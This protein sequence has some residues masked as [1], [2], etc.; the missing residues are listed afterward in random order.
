MPYLPAEICDLIIEHLAP[1]DYRARKAALHAL[2]LTNSFWYHLAM[3]E[4]WTYPRDLD[5]AE[6]ERLF[7]RSVRERP[8]LGMLVRS[9]K[10]TWAY[11]QTR[12][13]LVEI[14]A[15][16]PNLRGLVIRKEEEYSLSYRPRR[17]T[18]AH[19][20]TLAM[21]LANL[22][23]L[24]SL[25]LF[26][27]SG[28]TSAPQPCT[29]KC[30][31]WDQRFAMA[32]GKLQSLRIAGWEEWLCI[33]LVPH[34]SDQIRELNFG[35]RGV[36][37]SPFNCLSNGWS[38]YETRGF[39]TLTGFC[40]VVGTS[41]RVLRLRGHDYNRELAEA[42]PYLVALEELDTGSTELQ[43]PV[44]RILA[45]GTAPGQSFRVLLIDN[46][47]SL[48]TSSDISGY[49]DTEDY[50][51]VLWDIMAAIIRR[52]APTLRI[53]ETKAA[54]S[55]SFVAACAEAPNLQELRVCVQIDVGNEELDVLLDACPHVA[56]PRCSAGWGSNRAA[57]WEKR[58]L[59]AMNL[60]KRERDAE[61][62]L[63]GARSSRPAFRSHPHVN[64]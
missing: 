42:L 26:N 8:E 1:G 21:M 13:L 52:H 28:T 54:T 57:E 6:R 43:I 45:N 14:T 17:G 15:V 16:C 50:D 18:V 53:F 27:A 35:S 64:W 7:L 61:G 25:G 60:E 41:L 19:V 10:L 36:S 22:P 33:A 9:L 34:L 30:A 29:N 24:T 5:T 44:L 37:P 12:N 51:Q 39:T 58:E 38:C 2:S 55:S 32:A 40:E 47:P 3:R 46:I 62:P 23:H 59:E 31:Y 48:W 63:G 4:I 56:I 20:Q 49:A 11:R